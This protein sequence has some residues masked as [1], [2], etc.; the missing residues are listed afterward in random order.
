MTD[1]M[2]GAN[3]AMAATAADERIARRAHEIYLFRGGADGPALADWLEAE[4]EL[5]AEASPS[6]LAA[7][8][9]PPGPEYG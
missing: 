6:D 9:D 4:A 7:G 1:V 2:V 8:I 3:L 5:K